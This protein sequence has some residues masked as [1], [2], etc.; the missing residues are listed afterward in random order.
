[1]IRSVLLRG[2]GIVGQHGVVFALCVFI[3]V[4]HA[5]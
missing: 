3:R 4:V 5:C 2:G 1:M